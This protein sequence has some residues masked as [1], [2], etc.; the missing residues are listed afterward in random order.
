MDRLVREVS[1]R[2][3]LDRGV[4]RWVLGTLLVY[5]MHWTAADDWSELG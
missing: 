4:A 2:L 1:T 5:V 3:D